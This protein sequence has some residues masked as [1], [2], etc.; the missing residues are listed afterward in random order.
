[1][2]LV[3]IGVTRQS[4]VHSTLISLNSVPC[5]CQYPNLDEV[6]HSSHLAFV[7]RVLQ[8]TQ[9][10][11]SSTRMPANDPPFGVLRPRDDHPL[12]NIL[13]SA[14][15]TVPTAQGAGCCQECYRT[16]GYQNP[17][18]QCHHVHFDCAIAHSRAL[19]DFISIVPVSIFR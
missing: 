16:F 11:P 1:M 12:A 2:H 3:S 17:E 14:V 7:F 10:G 6:L 13:L 19:G 5:S 4:H 8:T 9:A 15:W 18:L